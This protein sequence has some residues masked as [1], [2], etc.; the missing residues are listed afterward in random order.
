M[1]LGS[2][3]MLLACLLIQITCVSPQLK[4]NVNLNA[5]LRSALLS[6]LKLWSTRQKWESCIDSIH[7]IHRALVR[8]YLGN[9]TQAKLCMVSHQE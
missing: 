5:Q 3:P 2:S 6:G 4:S 9:H 7:S 8:Q 1:S